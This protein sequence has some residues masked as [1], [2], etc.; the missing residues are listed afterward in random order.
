MPC[1]IGD[2]GKAEVIVAKL[3]CIKLK[4]LALPA[5]RTFHFHK[6]LVILQRKLKRRLWLLLCDQ[7]CIY[8][9]GRTKQEAW[10]NFK[11]QLLDCYRDWLDQDPETHTE[12]CIALYQKYLSLFK[13]EK[14]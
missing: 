13:V 7:L 14:K 11:W 12:Q 1:R 9:V 5:N 4:E 2:A 10:E 8:D 6:P 3:K